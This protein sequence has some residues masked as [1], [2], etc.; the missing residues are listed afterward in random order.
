MSL[1]TTAARHA[2][3]ALLLAQHG[4][5]CGVSRI[6]DLVAYLTAPWRATGKLQADGV[7]NEEAIREL[8]RN[9]MA[10]AEEFATRLNAATDEV[11]ADLQSVRD[12]LR[13]ALE[14]VETSNQAAVDAA[15]SKLDAPIA[16]LE[17][18][19]QDPAN[20]VPDAP[21]DGSTP[22]DVS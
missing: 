19:G 11:A 9:L 10:T 1:R 15:L 14:G 8:R 21:V 22:G 20:P 18:L 3:P 12:E 7:R 16:R 17:S 5:L 13:A 4:T 2:T 6:P